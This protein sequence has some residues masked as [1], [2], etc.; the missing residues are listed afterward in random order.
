MADIIDNEEI[1]RDTVGQEVLEQQF[2]RKYK[3]LAETVVSLKKSYVN[4]LHGTK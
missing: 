3:L 1:D 2:S 4:K